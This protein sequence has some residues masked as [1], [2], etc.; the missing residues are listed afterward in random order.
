MFGRWHDFLWTDFDPQALA[1]AWLSRET[2]W[3]Q[4]EEKINL[5]LRFCFLVHMFHRAPSAYG[6]TSRDNELIGTFIMRRALVG[7]AY[8]FGI[9]ILSRGGK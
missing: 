4:R 9:T 2:K 3:L 7:W 1:V 8:E 5:I 6:N